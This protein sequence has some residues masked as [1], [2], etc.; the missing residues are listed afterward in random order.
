MHGLGLLF[1]R[2]LKKRINV[3][4][5]ALTGKKSKVFLERRK[6]ENLVLVSNNSPSALHFSPETITKSINFKKQQNEKGTTDLLI[7]SANVL[8]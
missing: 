1:S 5:T 3:Y 7:I 8:L 2:I 6:S 4:V